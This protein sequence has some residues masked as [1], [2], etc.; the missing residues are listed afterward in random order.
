M[1]YYRY[2]K[3]KINER[4]FMGRKKIFIDIDEELLKDKSYDPRVL[5]WI[6]YLCAFNSETEESH[7]DLDQ[8]R[9]ALVPQC[10]S[11][12]RFNKAIDVLYNFGF[13]EFDKESFDYRLLNKATC[14]WFVSIDT[15][16]LHFLTYSGLDNFES[17][18]FI[19]LIGQ[20][21]YYNDKG[22]FSFSRKKLLELLGYC[23]NSRNRDRLEQALG[24]LQSMN[25]VTISAP[26]YLAGGK[27]PF[28]TVINVD[29]DLR[30]QRL[31]DWSFDK[32][33]VSV[34]VPHKE[35]LVESDIPAEDWKVLMKYDKSYLFIQVYA[36]SLLKDDDKDIERDL[37]GIDVE[38]CSKVV[39][40]ILEKL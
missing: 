27:G 32:G 8:V 12:Y 28:R 2:S 5:G 30:N 22:G 23:D 11:H 9:K 37:K 16:V 34:L 29:K 40:D 6:K 36:Y 24:M 21:N 3:D 17:K 35:E 26:Y 20:D 1:L 31:K 33:R 10:L 13:I 14:N 7:F 4:K 15:K 18:L 25:L 39:N 19:K 38:Y